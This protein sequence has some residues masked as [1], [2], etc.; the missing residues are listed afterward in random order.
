V[1]F[2]MT[3]SSLDLKIMRSSHIVF[4]EVKEFLYPPKIVDPYSVMDM[5][6]GGLGLS[7]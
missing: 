3:F 5:S 6:M 1:I 2:E 7:H 4:R